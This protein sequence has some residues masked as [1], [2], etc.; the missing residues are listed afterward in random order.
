MGSAL[1]VL[2]PVA[3]RNASAELED[4][5]VR[6]LSDSGHRVSVYTTED[7]DDLGDRIQAQ[8]EAAAEA[9]VDC[10]IAVGGD[11][12]VAAVA[13]R[14][15]AAGAGSVPLGIVP[16][17]TANVLAKEL[18]IPT[19]SEAAIALIAGP[20]E[21][22]P[23]DAMALLQPDGA[24][25][26]D[27]ATGKKSARS[28][29]LL[30]IGIGVDALMIRDTTREAKRRIGRL[31]YVKTFLQKA[32]GHEAHTFV[33]RVDG[34]RVTIPAWQVLV[35]N[36]GTLGTPPFQWGPHIDPGDGVL[37][38]CV[39]NVRS[40]KDWLVFLWRILTLNHRRDSNQRYFRVRKSLRIDT[41]RPLAVQA[42]GEVV[43]TT[44]IEVGVV[45]HALRV[46]VPAA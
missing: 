35:A 7:V 9:G 5:V 22:M 46:V 24:G 28:L 42:D 30:Q 20:H 18:G 2:N 36:V 40:W 38:L 13:E 17:G 43:G 11:G 29:H 19:A 10:V 39:Y 37:N 1:V 3:G 27:A 41:L 21:E 25:P 4:V 45:P 14:L 31:A 23:L 15:I 33:M 26:V 44:P 32:L 16:A 12:T 34:E 6:G 8:I